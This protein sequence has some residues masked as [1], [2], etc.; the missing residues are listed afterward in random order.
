MLLVT[1]VFKNSL[2]GLPPTYLT[3]WNGRMLIISLRS[4]WNACY[5]SWGLVLR[6]RSFHIF[7]Y[8]HRDEY[9]KLMSCVEL[10]ND[11]CMVVLSWSRNSRPLWQPKVHCFVH[12]NPPMP[13]ILSQINSPHIVIR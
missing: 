6:G 12:K 2:F 11:L 4:H 1:Q 8:G 7:C 3:M 5:L 9:L 13:L 10:R